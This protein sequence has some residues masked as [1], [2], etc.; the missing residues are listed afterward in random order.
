[1]LDLHAPQQPILYEDQDRKLDL[2]SS[3]SYLV[4][5]LKR[6][7]FLFILPFLIIILLGALIIKFIPKTFQAEGEILVESQKMAPDLFRPSITQ[8][9]D[10]RFRAFSAINYGARQSPVRYE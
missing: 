4:E 7:F 2:S 5:V 6:H 8:L 9:F 1:M 10:E 3:L